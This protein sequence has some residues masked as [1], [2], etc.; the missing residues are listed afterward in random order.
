MQ[1]TAFGGF[2]FDSWEF[3]P[4]LNDLRDDWILAVV[5][6]RRPVIERVSPVG[7]GNFDSHREVSRVGNVQP[8]ALPTNHCGGVFASLVYFVLVV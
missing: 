5:L 8:S 4:F 6:L 1:I 2:I 3:L 7:S